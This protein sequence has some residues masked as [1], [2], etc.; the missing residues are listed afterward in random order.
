MTIDGK[1]VAING[2]KN[3]LELVR[4]VGID[5]P[6]FCYHS[7]LSVYGACRMCLVEEQR[8]GLMAACSTKPSDG[9]VIRTTSP[10]LLRLRRNILELL[11]ANHDR[12]CTTCEKNGDCRLQELSD[13]FGIRRVRFGERQE[14]LPI[15]TSSP[16]LVRDPNKCVLCG[17]CVRMCTEIQG[18]GV[19]GFAYRGADTRIVPA[20][21]KPLAE[22]ECVGCGQC[23]SVCPTGALTVKPEIDKVWAALADPQK[24]VIIQVAPA[25][26]VA[27]GEE[28]GLA[29]GTIT[30]GKMV[31]AIRRL[32]PDQVY[33][34]SYAAD[35][36]TLEEG[37]EFLARLEKGERLPLFTSCCPAWVKYAEQFLPRLLPNLSSCRSP[38]QM[39]GSVIKRFYAKEK[40]LLPENV[41]FVSVMPCTAKKFEARRPEFA[42]NGVPDV[43]AVLSTKELAR[44][45][46]E[47]GIVFQELE[48]EP[49]DLPFGFA[50]GAGVGFGASGGVSTAVIRLAAEKFGLP[51]VGDVTYE[52]VPDLPNVRQAIVPL[53]DKTLRV[54][55][56]FTLAATKR[57]LA[58][59][60][61]RQAQYDI[62]EVMSCPGGCIGGGGQPAPSDSDKRGARMQAMLNADRLQ[63]IRAAQDNPFLQQMYAKWLLAPGSHI[64]HET[65]H[66]TYGSRRRIIGEAIP[67]INGDRAR[68]RVSVC[69]GTSCYA[70]GAYQVIQALHSLID[71]NNIS[72]LVDLEAT[73]CLENCQNGP[74]VRVNGRVFSHVT[75]DSV[76]QLFSLIEAETV[77]SEPAREGEPGD[78]SQ[79]SVELS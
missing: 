19:L 21:G 13:R 59:L 73:F 30:T 24:T 18:I 48:E 68:V 77:A 11:L 57:L 2:E 50:T 69:V 22:V 61:I 1:A 16:C 70:R 45:I 47:M 53:G 26:R 9:M 39:F 10:R 8:F 79:C 67:L 71:K 15:D 60:E 49:F 63:Q 75:P 52:P 36:T 40:G 38:Q 12:D 17:D 43:D 51:P 33:D 44:M 66:T 46:R 54:A 62:V 34:T 32:G 78:R 74:S 4:K 27:L 56:V 5:L 35:L 64:A 58:A 14:Q 3:V 28:F 6:T 72:D 23:V 31:A 7:E 29:P 42:V 65:L 37:T 41:F 55:V 20:F 25:V 76:E